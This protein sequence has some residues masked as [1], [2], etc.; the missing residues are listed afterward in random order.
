LPHAKRTDIKRILSHSQALNQCK[1]YLKK[2]FPKASVEAFS[3]SGA[4]I[5][6]LVHTRDKSIAVIAP[7][8]AAKGLKIMAKNIE[9]EKDNYTT[10]LAIEAGDF[11]TPQNKT[12]K[13]SIAFHFSKDSPG[14]LFTVFKDFADAKINLTRIESRPTKAKYGDYIFYLDFEGDI[15][16]KK[17][18]STLKKVKDKVERLKVLGSY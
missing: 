5:D 17:I 6:K 3:S 4:A 2:N 10:F 16:S 1:K 18:Q 11:K 13:T 15:H 14:S 12:R 9:N 7:Q 8:Q